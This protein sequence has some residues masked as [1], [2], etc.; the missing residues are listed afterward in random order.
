[1]RIQEKIAWHNRRRVDA[2]HKRI[3]WV[4]TCV[5]VVA[6]DRLITYNTY[7]DDDDDEI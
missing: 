1:M 6:I 4:I 2:Y 7:D 5:V 3:L